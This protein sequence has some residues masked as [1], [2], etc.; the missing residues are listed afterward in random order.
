MYSGDYREYLV[1]NAPSG[2]GL[3]TTWCGSSGEDWFV[4]PWN[5]NVNLYKQALLAPYVA[6]AIQVYRCPGDYI[7]SKNGQRIR[8]V[9]MNGMVGTKLAYNGPTWM[10]YQ[11]T[12]DA[13]CPG[14]ANE[15]VFAD[16]NMCSINDGYLQVTMGTP[17]YP[18]V[19]AAY[20]GGVNCFTFIDGHGEPHKWIGGVLTDQ[21]KCPY[22]FG[23]HVGGVGTTASDRDWIWLTNHSSCKIN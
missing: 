1:P 12:S 13:G 9:S 4:N 17:T 14:P 15:W 2:G 11:K 3:T 23:I 8:S 5:T 19:P 7:P 18:D 16:E 20:H 10:L 21:S 6:N 22:T